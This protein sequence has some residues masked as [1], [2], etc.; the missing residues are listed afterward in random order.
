[1]PKKEPLYPHVPKSRAKGASQVKV[2][3]TGDRDWYKPGIHL[4]NPS[5]EKIEDAKEDAINKGFDT[6]YV[7]RVSPVPREKE[8]EYISVKLQPIDWETLQWDL[9]MAISVHKKAGNEQRAHNTAVILQKI[10]NQLP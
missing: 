5:P 9:D 8:Q 2:I 10:K 1:M 4:R 6:V 3:E 7:H